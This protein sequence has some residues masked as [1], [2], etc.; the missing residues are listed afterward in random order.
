MSIP[1]LIFV[2]VFILMIQNKA[3]KSY[4]LSHID[5]R[6]SFSKRAVYEGEQMELID[7]ITNRKLLPLL[8]LQLESKI[9]RNLHF[10]QKGKEQ[11][12]VH[13]E[14]FHRALFSLMPYQKSHTKA[15][16]N[17]CKTWFLSDQIRWDVLRG[18]LRI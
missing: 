8:W 15:T 13:N 7:E 3:Y 6:R 1:W 11:L 10:Q 4:S 5:Y 9:H 14:Q 2:T 18:C 12:E 16:T 17:M